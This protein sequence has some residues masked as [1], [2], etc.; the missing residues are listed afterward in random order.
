[1]ILVPDQHE[2]S[3]HRHDP[4]TEAGARSVLRRFRDDL[5]EMLVHMEEQAEQYANGAGKTF[6]AN[7]PLRRKV[8]V[9]AAMKTL[10]IVTE[11][12]SANGSCA[13]LL[14]AAGRRHIANARALGW[15][16]AK[17]TL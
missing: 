12:E 8:Y 5:M 15:L 11:I 4:Y 6:L 2:G 1:M 10:G 14:T 13:L 3:Q 7:S 9:A 17:E 16:P